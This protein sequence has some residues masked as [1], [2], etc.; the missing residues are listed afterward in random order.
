MYGYGYRYNSGLVLGAGGGAPF[1]NTYSL[2]FDG[3]D[4]FVATNA[5]YSE[6][7]GGTKMTLSV[8]L[9]PISGAPILEYI[10]TN[11]RNGTANQH[12]FGLVLYENNRVQFDVQAFASQ[13]VIADINAI[14]YGQWNH[15]LVCVDLDRTTGT[16]GAIF[17]NGVDET[18]NSLMGT[19]S[20]FYSATGALH[21]GIHANGG[22]NPY[23]G[24]MD[25][26]AIWSGQDYRNAS[27][28]N[29]IYNS[30]SPTDLNN[31]SEIAQ[32][33]TWFRFEEGSGTTAIDSG[34]GGNNGT[35][36]NGV[37]YSTNVP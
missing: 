15:I 14:T 9:K 25:E 10:V 11:P 18:T 21:I 35:L 7:D 23:N 17:I 3:I 4:D 31:T 26:L 19:L 34:S 16:E 13:Y 1:A 22:Y 29:S 32:P 33:N 30:G 20:S 6:L 2:N 5:I 27:E 8:W 28:V 12:Q 36:N 24:A 37:A